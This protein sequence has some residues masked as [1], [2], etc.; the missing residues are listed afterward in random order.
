MTA[1]AQ[2]KTTFWEVPNSAS[3][4]EDWVLA[5]ANTPDVPLV[6][7]ISY[8]ELE[9]QTTADIMTRFDTECMKLGLRGCTIVV[10]SG[11][12]GV[13]G[14]VARQDKRE[15]GIHSGFPASA[16][17]VTVVGGTQGPEAGRDEVACSS[18]TQ[19]V[20]TTGGGFSSTFAAPDW[21]AQW[22]EQFLNTSTTLPS[23]DHYNRKGR[24][25][26]DVAV[27]ARNYGTPRF[28]PPLR[29]HTHTHA[30]AYTSIHR[31]THQRQLPR[32]QWHECLGPSL[33]SNDH[34][35]E[36]QENARW[37]IPSRLSESCPV[38]GRGQ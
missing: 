28:S 5:V 25:Y 38:R 8:G 29:T 17:H 20:I 7:S 30:Y 14:V 35:R 37:E 22:V 16:P 9:F 11:D 31:A 2:A 15:C 3:P 23:E 6:H 21:Q 33:C 13:A 36:R 24:A 19:G 26:P 10:A 34:P 4:F 12:D 32:R 27:L 18:K 1:V